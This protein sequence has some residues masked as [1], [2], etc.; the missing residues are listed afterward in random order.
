ER[1][2]HS[3]LPPLLAVK[4]GVRS[5]YLGRPGGLLT[6]AGHPAG[7][8]LGA[9]ALVV[10]PAAAFGLGGVVAGLLTVTWTGGTLLIRRRWYAVYALLVAAATPA[11]FL[12]E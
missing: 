12:L 6:L 10:L 1:V 3:S 4:W 11:I 8:A 5:R 9:A 2:W 7:L